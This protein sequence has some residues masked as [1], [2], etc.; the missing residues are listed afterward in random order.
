MTEWQT[1]NRRSSDRAGLARTMLAGVLILVA[2]TVGLE[3]G[4]RIGKQSV[5]GG[6][7]DLQNK[8]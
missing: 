6:S 5:K 2:L 8:R 4:Y 1:T 7:R 3:C